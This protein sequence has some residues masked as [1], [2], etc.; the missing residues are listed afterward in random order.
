MVQIFRLYQWFS[1]SAPQEVARYAEN[2]LALSI[3]MQ[4]STSHLCEL[5]FSLL[6]KYK[7]INIFLIF[8]IVICFTVRRESKKFENH[9]VILIIYRSW[10]LYPYGWKTHKYITELHDI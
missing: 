1:N 10:N 9:R 8:L 7:Y 3:L 4:F 6:Y 5:G 2:I